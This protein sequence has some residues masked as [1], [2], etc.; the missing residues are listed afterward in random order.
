M[1]IVAGLFNNSLDADRAI[2]ELCGEKIDEN[3]TVI[4]G[5]RF[6]M[7]PQRREGA[8]ESQGEIGGEQVRYPGI[9]G[10]GLLIFA[11]ENVALAASGLESAGTKTEEIQSA[12][13]NT[14]VDL[15]LDQEQAAFSMR[16]LLHGSIVVVA[17]VPEEREQE[18]REIVRRAKGTLAEDR[19]S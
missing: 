12:L 19:I 13:I 17:R 3:C 5:E 9:V 1:K 6:V 15:G 11:G 8:A 10:P 16:G 2:N 4:N 18:A 14:L 7:G